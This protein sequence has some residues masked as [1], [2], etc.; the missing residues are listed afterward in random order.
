MIEEVVTTWDGSLLSTRYDAET[1]SFFAIA[2]H[3]RK[4]GPACGGTRAKHYESYAAA[5]ADATRL[6]SSM[7]LKMAAA[8]LPMGGGKSVIA[9]PAPRNEIGEDHWRRIL[10]V[11]AEN[12]QTLNGSYWT[13]PDVGTSATDMDLLFDRS[14]FAFGRTEAAGGPGSSAPSTAEGVYVAMQATAAEK[15]MESLAGRRIAIQGLGAVGMDVA[16]FALADGASVTA[17]DIDPGLCRIAAEMGATIVEP[18]QILDVESD[19]FSPCAMGEVVDEEIAAA[20]RTSVIAGGANNVLTSAAAGE[21]LARR[22][23]LLA[24]DFIA[25]S[26]GGMH[27]IGREVLGWSPE[28]VSDHVRGI[29]TTLREVFDRSR[30]NGVAP[31]RAARDMVETRLA[32]A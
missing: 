28:E 3:S 17:T 1:E 27:L 2:I 22:D 6:A 29:G 15:G 21:E 26:G 8:G 23:I 32:S 5:V 19:V 12:L 18:S 7:T 13:G 25:N 14:G 4:R 20:I 31:D 24:P 30:V 9:L 10:E 11:Q 16:K